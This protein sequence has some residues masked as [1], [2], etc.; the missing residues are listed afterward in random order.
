MLQKTSVAA[1]MT[2]I[3]LVALC[4]LPAWAA[5]STHAQ[6]LSS[7]P[8]T[9]I[10]GCTVELRLNTKKAIADRP[11]TY[12]LRARAYEK[13]GDHD[14]ALADRN[15]AIRLAPKDFLP[16]LSR[17][18]Q[19]E[20]MGDL[21]RAAADYEKAVELKPDADGPKSSL[22]RVRNAMARAAAAQAA[23]AAAPSGLSA[24]ATTTL[25][26]RCDEF[27]A[28]D[29]AI[30]A[31]STLLAPE[32]GTSAPLRA[33]AH[34]AR[35]VALKARSQH[36]EAER[37]LEQAIALLSERIEA[38]PDELDPLVFRAAAFAL[39]GDE[40]RANQD[41][42]EYHRR[43]GD[44]AS[45]SLTRGL[46][47]EWQGELRRAESQ[48]EAALAMTLPKESAEF[49]GVSL[50]RVRDKLGTS[51]ALPRPA[52][53]DQARD[54][55]ASV[56]NADVASSVPTSISVATSTSGPTGTSVS[57]STSVATG[58]APAAEQPRDA[59]PPVG[60]QLAVAVA[61]AITAPAPSAPI[62]RETRVALVIGN[63]DYRNVPKLPNPPR[64]A[65]AIAESLR[66]VGFT[67]VR[68]S[69]NL[70]R[71]ATVAAL[72]AFEREAEKADWAVVYYAGHGIEVGG[73]NYL[74]PV[75]AA[76]KIDK[77]VQDEAVPLDRVLS[78]IE[79]A[80]RLRLVI[81]DACRDN[82]F[83]TSM[84][85]SIA[86]RS[87]GR[88]LAQIEPDGGVLVAYAAKHGQVALDGDGANSPFVAA[89]VKRLETPG[90]D[91]SL[92]FRQVRD[93]VLAATRRQQ[94]PYVYGSLPGEVLSFRPH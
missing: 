30:E 21:A 51:A 7:D 74:I 20:K 31:C 37:D 42:D 64:D 28:P 49:V 78:A 83:V 26:L 91:I 33:R 22:E 40:A 77:D 6:C 25:L 5:E 73:V 36:V 90:L 72:R 85:R 71:D 57:T 32:N 50:A 60:A 35:A 55:D 69:N 67:T 63:A 46:V 76:L 8:D 29:V 47:L 93:D 27:A 43:G 2:V 92:L 38:E 13:K 89:L 94:E 58:D 62:R 86:S 9:A 54:G 41:Y 11:Y 19:F 4:S 24:E 1:I 66:R 53:S 12:S 45:V 52:A 3:G 15:E 88:G 14:R 87:I 68:V 82:P 80:K 10:R 16:Y 79:S 44:A 65:D 56:A 81:L 18:L 75:D 17:G 61:P 34:F 48:Y 39:K 59:A 70:S 23:P 84:K